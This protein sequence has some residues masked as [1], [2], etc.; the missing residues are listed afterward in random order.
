MKSTTLDSSYRVW[1]ESGA[2]K[3]TVGGREVGK[4]LTA[5]VIISHTYSKSSR[6][7]RM[8]AKCRGD[9][10]VEGLRHR[11]NTRVWYQYGCQHRD[12][13]VG[14]LLLSFDKPDTAEPTASEQRKKALTGTV[15]DRITSKSL[16]NTSA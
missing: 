15:D 14:G 5:H 9:K 16:C 2:G 6:G 12:Q 4:E 11:H 1:C 7:S 3:I 13:G 8:V 10:V